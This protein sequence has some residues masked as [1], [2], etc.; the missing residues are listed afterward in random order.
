MSITTSSKVNIFGFLAAFLLLV[1]LVFSIVG[2]ASVK[3]GWAK[4]ELDDAF[5]FDVDE[6]SLEV[7]LSGDTIHV[8]TLKAQFGGETFTIEDD[9]DPRKGGIAA[10]VGCSLATL[11]AFLGV[12]AGVMTGLRKGPKRIG[13]ITACL[14]FLA[15]FGLLIAVILYAALA[16]IDDFKGSY[17]YA[18][19]LCAIGSVLAVL[20]AISIVL[21]Y[22]VRH[23][24]P[25]QQV[26]YVAM[27]AR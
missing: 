1:V 16:N 4:A 5:S 18:F 13:F 21:G 12:I 25:R 7:T 24:R 23:T 20:A 14:A 27:E 17:D 10:I 3:R 26:E 2:L 8:G 9:L 19:I 15:C 11:F 22:Y 6:F